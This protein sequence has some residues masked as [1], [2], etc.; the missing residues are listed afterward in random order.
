MKSFRAA[1]C[2]VSLSV[3]GVSPRAA[4]QANEPD[5]ARIVSSDIAG[6]WRA[7]DHAAAKDSA[8]LVT[9]IR[10]EYLARPSPGLKSWMVV[11]LMS[12][13]A[14]LKAVA[15]KGWDQQ[16]AM[17]AFTAAETSPER[18]AFDAEV[19]PVVRESAAAN[20][21]R[22]YL[23]RRGY[24]DAIRT[25]TLAV[26]TSRA[27]KD[28]VRAAFRRLEA[29]YPEAN[30]PD[31][32][33]LIGRMTSGGT[34]SG[35]QLLIGTEIFGRD[36]S[37]PLGELNAWERAVTGQIKDLP[38]IVAHEFAHTLQASR[39][40]P[41]TL[42][43]AALGEGSADFI[44]ELISGSHIINPAYT[45]GDAREKELW[46]EFKAAMDSSDTSNWLYQGDR[47]TGGRPADLGY[48]MGYKIAKAY[49]ERAADKKAAV[50][51]ILRFSDAKAFLEASGYGK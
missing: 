50:K 39:G 9:A 26:D 47:A 15:S 27:V 7:V 31:V 45:Y 12:T 2:V 40:G 34:T 24:Y 22:K 10:E 1:V 8:S 42:L 33:F 41:R 36:P 21:A 51:Q 4:A 48:W 17:R 20:L 23:S 25:N 46:A 18:I 3:V 14:V 6:F 38:N 16:R 30:Y 5:S 32:Y 37:T 49:Y 35:P 13:D 44:A 29:L 43:G 19:M 11:R 28:S